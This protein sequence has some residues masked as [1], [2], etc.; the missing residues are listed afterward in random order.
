MN[1]TITDL[2]ELQNT[3]ENIKR[4]LPALRQECLEV[5]EQI[6]DSVGP[7]TWKR[8]G[9][10]VESMDRLY[11]Q[12]RRVA[13]T[14]AG[15]PDN[16]ELQAALG[17]FVRVFPEQFRVMN[18]C[19]DQEDYRDAADCLKYELAET[20]KGLAV[21]LGD[22]IE[23]MESRYRKNLEFLKAKYPKVYKE[24]ADKTP[25]WDNYQIFFSRTGMPNLKIR[26]GENRW[27]K[28][29]SNHDPEAEAS[30]WA[31]RLAQELGDSPDIILY[32][33][34][35]GYHLLML[36]VLKPDM[37]A[38][39]YEPDAQIFLAAMHAVELEPLFSRVNVISMVVGDDR[40]QREQM[41]FRFMKMSGAKPSVHAI[42]VY[43]KLSL[44]NM[45]DFREDAKTATMTYL[46]SVMT[47]RRFG[48]DWTRNRIFNLSS[49]LKSPSLGHYKG[50]LA[51]K[52]AVIV[53]GGPSLEPDI[54]VLRELK[55]HALIIAAGSSIQ[56][57]LYFG[58]EPHCFVIVDGGKINLKVYDNPAIQGIPMLFAP[59][60]YYQ[61][62][63]AHDRQRKIHF[64]LNEDLTTQYLMGL[65][66]G[67][68]LFDPVPS[69]TGNAIEAAIYM[70]CTEIV[71]VGQ[72][73]SYPMDK[74]YSPGAKHISPQRQEE[75]I[76]TAVYTVENVNG[77]HNRATH[78]LFVTLRSLEQL[79]DKHGDIRFTNTSRY[80]A[81]IGGAK[82]EPLENVL[83]RVKDQIVP[84]DVMARF[85]G[86][87]EA[88]HGERRRKET[89]ARLSILDRE[90]GMLEQHLGQIARKL[91]KLPELGERRSMKCI[92]FM[93]DIEKI[94][95][96]VTG[97][98]AFV[99]LMTTLSM[100]AIREFDRDRPELERET[101]VIRKAQLFVDVLG[102]L[103]EAM[104]AGIPD[105]KELLRTAT[106]RLKD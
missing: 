24:V 4:D 58:V 9:E 25:D 70:G 15:L 48:L 88:L 35:F 40:L 74:M 36:N 75:L 26:I 49:I 76:R 18:D 33:F 19:M 34:G 80:G 31:S 7:E 82:W 61:S 47:Y 1:E 68:P 37:Q 20:I 71:L 72:D 100:N 101:D 46:T 6:Y 44:R 59:M 94:W 86:V 30:R 16:D 8:I 11:R 10:L 62:V 27:V 95:G 103:V 38:A 84:E 3:L 53:G 51:G 85:L 105:L 77:G 87:P 42:P 92:Q 73:L 32:G 83:D 23:I 98:V 60:A 96:K 69:V 17:H 89:L 14:L 45:D 28:F 90:T 29:Y 22:E 63:D 54:P 43:E 21:A 55:K 2:Y 50:L 57:L 52:T 81:K 64:F 79:I 65:T 99:S 97:N 91:D 12:S 93:R 102:P 56:S 41:F 104:Q 78:G 39:I 5:A 13:G 66:N 67:D 106:E